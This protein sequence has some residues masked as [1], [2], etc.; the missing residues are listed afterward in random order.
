[1]A[2]ES[3]SVFMPGQ[4]NLDLIDEEWA[5]DV[6]SDDEIEFDPENDPGLDEHEVDGAL[7]AAPKEDED[8]KWQDLGIDGFVSG[9]AA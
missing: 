7:G 5:Q 4:D 3:D 6:L 9:N 1:M 2:L 8:E